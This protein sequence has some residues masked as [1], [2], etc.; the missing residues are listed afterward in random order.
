MKR[1]LKW[2]RRTVL[3]FVAL[4]AVLILAVMIFDPD[5]PQ[6]PERKAPEQKIAV[7]VL[8]AGA[9]EPPATA[10]K[11]NSSGNGNGPGE[12][13]GASAVA[14]APEPYTVVKAKKSFVGWH[15][16]TLE[17]EADTA[18]TPRQQVETMMQAAIDQLPKHNADVLSVRLWDDHSSGTNALNRLVY[19]PDGCGWAGRNGQPCDK[20]LWTDLLRGEIPPD[21]LDWN[22]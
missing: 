1:L 12:A 19:A 9:T 16:V 21:L 6:P 3:T 17:I 4:V 7:K 14:I 8:P 2:L 11:D 5:P 10:A 22:G 20:P 18:T 15:R 13:A